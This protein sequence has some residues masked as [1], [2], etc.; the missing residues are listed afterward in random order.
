MRIP[1]ILLLLTLAVAFAA[2]GGTKTETENTDKA[3]SL[4]PRYDGIYMGT[5]GN[6]TRLLHFYPSGNVVTIT[7]YATSGDS[8]RSLFRADLPVNIEKGIHNVPVTLRNDSVLFRTTVMQ[9]FIH[10]DGRIYGGDSLVVLKSS[11]ANGRKAA[12]TYY[13]SK[14]QASAQ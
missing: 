10:Y 11:Q 14:D 1:S 6:L 4:A 9:G 5:Y 2:C 12:I 7:G 3:T 8:L 13:F